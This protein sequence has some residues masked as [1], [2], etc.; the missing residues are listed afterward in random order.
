MSVVIEGNVPLYEEHAARVAVGYTLK[1]WYQMVPEERALEVAHFRL[2]ALVEAHS[3][4]E[5]VKDAGRK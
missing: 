4:A 3:Q 2:R 5:A 1:E